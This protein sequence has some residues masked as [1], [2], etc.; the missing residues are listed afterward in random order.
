MREL[1]VGWRQVRTREQVPVVQVRGSAGGLGAK[2]PDQ[3]RLQGPTVA[4]RFI[5]DF[6]AD[7]RPSPL[8]VAL[9]AGV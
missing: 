1:T 6:Q 5:G 3:L 9:P 4:L 2:R 7:G 8:G